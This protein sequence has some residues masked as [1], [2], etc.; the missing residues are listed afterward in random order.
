M[1]TATNNIIYQGNSTIS[2]EA[3]P[4]YSKPVVVKRPS[5]RNASR[6]YL[7]SLEREYELT[8]ALD[9]VAGVRQALG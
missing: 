9:G 6:H 5:E 8:H 2:V 3:L 1:E 7:S 4:A